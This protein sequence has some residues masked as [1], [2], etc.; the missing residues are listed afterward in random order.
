V[1]T[2]S[3][4]VFFAIIAS[5]LSAGTAHADTAAVHAAVQ[6]TWETACIPRS[7]ATRNRVTL[8]AD[9]TFKLEYL[10]GLDE[11]C[12]DAV[13]VITG[14][15][16]IGEESPAGSGEHE[17]RYRVASATLTTLTRL[18]NWGA[19]LINACSRSDW[20]VG[21]TQSILGLDCGSD[22]IV[23][24]ADGFSYDILTIRD[25]QLLLGFAQ[26]WENRLTPET[27]PST[28]DE[29]LPYSRVEGQ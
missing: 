27:A 9:G 29:E 25:G 19:N 10:R 6:G 3:L 14:T 7:Q 13:S 8:N 17:L 16:T 1:Q 23:P 4:T 20:E 24:A 28:F 15:Y 18:G 21:V 22:G 12:S 26:S 11:T 5:F 2:L